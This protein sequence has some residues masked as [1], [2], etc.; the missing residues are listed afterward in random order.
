M[1]RSIWAPARTLSV[2]G[3][4]AVAALVLASPAA[5]AGGPA[6]L[7]SVGSVI[8]DNSREAIALGV[9]ALVLVAGLLLLVLRRRRRHTVTTID[10]E[11]F[12]EGH[13][14]R[15][16]VGAF[17]GFVHAMAARRAKRG[18]EPEDVM[19]LVSDPRKPAPFWVRLDEISS[20]TNPLRS[21]IGYASMTPAERAAGSDSLAVQRGQIRDECH[22]RGWQLAEV[23]GDV[24][25][26]GAPLERTGRD[27]ALELIAAGDA[28][29]L[30]ATSIDRLA[31]SAADLAQLVERFEVEQAGL[32]VLDP[33]VDLSTESGKLVAQVIESVSALEK[34]APQ[35]APPARVEDRP[36]AAAEEPAFAEEPATG[37]IVVDEPHTE[38]VEQELQELAALQAEEAPQ[39]HPARG[40]PRRGT[41]RRG[42]SRRRTTRRGAIPG[43]PARSAPGRARAQRRTGHPAAP[44]R[45][46][47]TGPLAAVP[48]SHGSSKPHKA[49]HDH[50]M[51]IVAVDCSRSGEVNGRHLAASGELVAVDEQ[52][53]SLTRYRAPGAASRVA[54]PDH[55][56]PLQ[57]HRPG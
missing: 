34:T 23:V 19:Y 46:W 41:S 12:A 32:V 8:D 39:E 54:G 52:G 31:D 24:P 43:D 35:P 11:L 42:A 51:G 25:A 29:A 13:S 22:R 55:R 44:Q 1:D 21:V 18:E 16:G 57:P 6:T 48:L 40:A 36:P 47:P 7:G 20:L 27:R 50:P 26:E 3:I 9:G 4:A 5:A 30:I 15:N 28:S 17:S 2:L 38:M 10:H 49:V 14:R 53:R 45:R 56:N 33:N 37:A